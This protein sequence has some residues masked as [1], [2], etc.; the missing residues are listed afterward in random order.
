MELASVYNVKGQGKFNGQYGDFAPAV[1][2][3]LVPYGAVR[4]RCVVPL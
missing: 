1:T 3:V 2:K 4:K